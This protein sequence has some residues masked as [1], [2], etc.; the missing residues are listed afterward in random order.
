MAPYYNTD[1]Y[2]ILHNT[3]VLDQ[4]QIKRQWQQNGYWFGHTARCYGHDFNTNTY[5][6]RLCGITDELFKLD[7]KKCIPPDKSGGCVRCVSCGEYD[8]HASYLRSSYEDC[9]V[10]QEKKQKQLVE[11]ENV[12][13][14]KVRGLFFRNYLRERNEN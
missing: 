1:Y 5:D 4:I 14:S 6:C 7:P 2:N 8:A 9:Y 11:K 10:T 3:G 13:W 12:K